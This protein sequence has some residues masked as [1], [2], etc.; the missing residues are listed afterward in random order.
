MTIKEKNKSQKL[1]LNFKIR[2][3]QKT[4]FEIYSLFFKKMKI[5]TK[6]RLFKGNLGDLTNQISTR[7][8]T[9]S[10]K[11]INLKLIF[12]FLLETEIQI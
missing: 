2:L 1:L 6:I 7:A 4:K 10:R 12:Q 9:K 11:K 3:I 8:K 5:D